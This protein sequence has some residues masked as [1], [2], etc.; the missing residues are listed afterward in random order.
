MARY[1]GKNMYL[2]LAGTQIQAL[3][4]VN[5]S[6]QADEIDAS[7]VG[8]SY[9][10]YLAGLTEATMDVECLDDDA[11]SPV[12]HQALEP[13]VTGSLVF[14]PAGTAAGKLKVTIGTAVVLQR[15]R[16]TPYSD[17]AVISANIRLSVAPTLGTW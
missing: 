2:G 16:Q 13:S 9:K 5:W 8:D 10:Q 12:N 6:A 1:S 15:Q 11:A 17:V 7:A 3:R 4:S 14:G